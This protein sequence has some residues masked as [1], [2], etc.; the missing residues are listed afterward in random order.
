MNYYRPTPEEP[1]P[2]LAKQACDILQIDNLS[3]TSSTTAQLSDDEH[4]GQTIQE[5]PHDDTH[6]TSSDKTY[7]WND[8]MKAGKNQTVHRG[9][10]ED[11]SSSTKWSAVFHELEI[12]EEKFQ[13]MLAKNYESKTSSAIT[14]ERPNISSTRTPDSKE[15]QLQNPGSRNAQGNKLLE[16][17]QVQTPTK[18]NSEL[19]ENETL[20]T[21]ITQFCLT[22]EGEGMMEGNGL[23]AS[24]IDYGKSATVVSIH[25]RTSSNPQCW[26]SLKRV[27]RGNASPDSSIECSLVECL[28]QSAETSAKVSQGKCFSLLNTKRWARTPK[29]HNLNEDVIESLL[30][31]IWPS[32]GRNK[33]NGATISQDLQTGGEKVGLKSTDGGHI[34]RALWPATDE[35]NLVEKKD[36]AL[37]EETLVKEQK[38]EDTAR[39]SELVLIDTRADVTPPHIFQ[40]RGSAERPHQNP[41]L[42]TKILHELQSALKSSKTIAQSFAFTLKTPKKPEFSPSNPTDTTTPLSLEGF[43]LTPCESATHKSQDES[44]KK[45]AMDKDYDVVTQNHRDVSSNEWDMMIDIAISNEGI[46]GNNATFCNERETL[47]TPI[48]HRVFSTFGNWTR[49]TAT[50]SP[51]TEYQHQFSNHL[52]RELSPSTEEQSLAF[53]TPFGSCIVRESPYGERSRKSDNAVVLDSLFHQLSPSPEKD[54]RAPRSKIATPGHFDIPSA[55]GQKIGNPELVVVKELLISPDEVQTMKDEMSSFIEQEKEFFLKGEESIFDTGAISLSPTHDRGSA[56]VDT[57]GM[58][59]SQSASENKTNRST[60]PQFSAMSRQSQ[61]DSSSR[62]ESNNILSEADFATQLTQASSMESS[63]KD[64][65]QERLHYQTVPMVAAENCRKDATF[66]EGYRNVLHNRFEPNGNIGITQGRMES[67]SPSRG[68]IMQALEAPFQV[69]APDIVLKRSHLVSTWSRIA[70]AANEGLLVAVQSQV[71]SN[72]TSIL[73]N[74]W[75][76]IQRREFCNSLG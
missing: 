55:R 30:W 46:I 39:S 64:T 47:R 48:Q 50:K 13:I 53:D 59:E 40:G 72:N 4:E 22:F 66:F 75:K 57:K 35:S 63:G 27:L 28:L 44:S 6:T 25:H 2:V 1:N 37:I 69:S 12:Q 54:Q 58:Q 32:T 34:A 10:Q 45:M 71:Q 29:K 43:L 20:N 52:I 15:A 60:V 31:Q 36:S 38:R 33:G 5:N 26:T 19:K 14:C 61:S 49:Y 74:A 16:V 17:T 70:S 51:R 18:G 62:L 7:K 24:P 3:K 9:D 11:L 76:C 56:S 8:N 67:S 42:D 41:L 65:K 21:P 23:C 73:S 68:S